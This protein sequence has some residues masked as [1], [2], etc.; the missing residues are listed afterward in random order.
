MNKYLFKHKWWLLTT[1][2]IR[3]FGAALIVGVSIILQQIVDTALTGD[4]DRF[5]HVIT[6]AIVYFLV[7]AVND[8]LNRTTQLIYIKKTL[9]AFKADLFKGILNKDYKE[10]HQ[11]NSADYISNLTNDVTLVETKYITPLLELCGDFIIFFGSTAVLLKINVWITVAIFITALLLFIIPILFGKT[12]SRLQN[13]VSS[14]LSI[15]TSQIKDIFQGYEVIKSYNIE[16]NITKEFEKGNIEL[17]NKK[18]KANY[19]LGISMTCTMWLSTMTQ[20]TAIGLGGYFLIVGAISVGSL[21]AVVQLGNGIYGPIQWVVQKATTVKSMKA[22]NQKLLTII[23]HNNQDEKLAHALR[24]NQAIEVKDVVF[25]YDQTR[26]ALNHVSFS[27]EKGKKYAIVGKSGSGKSTIVKLM[28]GYYTDYEGQILMDSKDIKGLSKASLNNQMSIIH[29]NVYMFDKNIKENIELGKTFSQDQL[30]YALA[31]SG[32][33][34][35]LPILPNGVETMVGENGSN[36]SGGQKQ[37]VAIARSLIQETPILMLDEG[38]SALDAKTAYDIEDT[39]LK[40]DDLT[41][42]T[43][44]HKLSETM[45][46]RYDQIIVME[47]GQIVEVGHFNQ[48][49]SHQGPFMS[50]Y[51]VEEN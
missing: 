16:D 36:L 35:F 22:I 33:K 6:V 21:M 3:A 31:S 11:E 40:L 20:A 19:I 2:L 14:Q 23:D 32:L 8:Y 51:H 34:E 38:T 39:L 1:V 42:I 28:S 17:E 7:M 10:Y 5:W 49:T 50:L 27:F 30:D 13:V 48:L 46:S 47:Q 44:T 29:Q 41:I 43:I 15:F 37:R 26:L 24:F 45:L 18:Y 12:I 4:I 9:I 25:G